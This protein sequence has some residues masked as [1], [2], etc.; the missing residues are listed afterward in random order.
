ML[1]ALL[2][3]AIFRATCLV[4]DDQISLKEHFHLL[5]QTLE[6]QVPGQMLHH[7]MTEK[8]VAILLSATVCATCLATFL[9]VARYFTL[10]NVSGHFSRHGAARQVAPEGPSISQ[11]NFNLPHTFYV[12]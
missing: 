1:K 4:F 5:P 10:A 8:V 11:S 12:P 6:A 9:A 7:A 2:N 3:S